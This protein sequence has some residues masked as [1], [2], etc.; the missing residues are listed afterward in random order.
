MSLVIIHIVL[1]LFLCVAAH[2]DYKSY[3]IGNLLIVSGVIS[4]VTLNIFLPAGIGFFDSFAGCGVGLL[5]LLP[6]YLLHAMGAGDIK[7]MAM[8]GAFV[9]PQEVLISI[10]YIMITG[11]MLAIYVAAHRG[12]LKSSLYRALVIPIKFIVNLFPPKSK[13]RLNLFLSSKVSH[14]APV[15]IPYGIAIAIGTTIFLAVHQSAIYSSLWT[16]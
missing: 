12:V 2:Q 3:R 6:F 14:G 10:F 11:G 4:G 7:L 16:Q 13:H 9:G 1:L 8:V 5:L 15:K